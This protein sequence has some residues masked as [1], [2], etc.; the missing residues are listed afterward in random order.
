MEVIKDTFVQETAAH[1]MEFGKEN[2]VKL[3][4]W[5][6]EMVKEHQKQVEDFKK[7]I[8]DEKIRIDMLARLYE[9][10]F[11]EINRTQD[12]LKTEPR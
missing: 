4:K 11:N 12:L 8:K 2:S 9:I 3:A 5:L 6:L 7:N 10:F 1:F